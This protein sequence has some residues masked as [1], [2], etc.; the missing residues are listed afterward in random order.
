MIK[1]FLFD[2]DG[3]LF[4]TESLG[5]DLLAVVAVKHGFTL[6]RERQLAMLGATTATNEMQFREWFGDAVDFPRYSSDW[7]AMMYDYTAQH[8]VRKMKGAEDALHTLKQRGLKL[9]LCSSSAERM[10]R[11]YLSLAGWENMFDAVITGNMVKNGKPAPDIF[12]KGAEALGV[13]PDECVGVEDSVNGIRALRAAG[14]TSVMVP[15]LIPYTDELSPYVDF[16][17]PSLCELESTIF[18]DSHMKG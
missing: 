4:D 17:I 14:M 18:H 15:D 5:L 11:H 2:M 1:A 6:S 16:C 8:G 7:C 13:S 3:L 9:A 12:L 10:V